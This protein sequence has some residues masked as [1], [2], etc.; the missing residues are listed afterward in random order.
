MKTTP[1]HV[2]RAAAGMLPAAVLA[3]LGMP[4][5]AA[6][7]FLAVMVLVVICWI[8]SDP[9]RSDRVNRILL[10]RRGDAR[11]L[12]PGTSARSSPVSR[13]RRSRRPA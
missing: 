2:G 8:I 9:G 7:V 3:R 13:P 12:E 5:L 10:A 4:A 1:K 6:L 11:C